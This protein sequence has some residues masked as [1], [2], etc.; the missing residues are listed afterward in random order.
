[1]QSHCRYQRQSICRHWVWCRNR[2]MTRPTTSTTYFRWLWTRYEDSYVS[3]LWMKLNSHRRLFQVVFLPFA[4]AM[5]VWRWDIFNKNIVADQY[6]CHWWLLRYGIFVSFFWVRGK[7]NT[8]L[9][10]SENGM[11]AS[12]RQYYGPKWTLIRA[13]NFIYQRTFHTSGEWFLC[14]HHFIT[15]LQYAFWCTFHVWLRN[16]ISRAAPRWLEQEKQV[17]EMIRMIEKERGKEK[18][19]KIELIISN[20]MNKIKYFH[21]LCSAAAHRLTYMFLFLI[22]RHK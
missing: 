21:T 18:K 10:I 4:L 15:I 17:K 2:L 13:P 5:D 14:S 1:M 22:F 19:I 6:N 9:N 3:P 20:W 12:N 16:A 7:L 8:P 11:E